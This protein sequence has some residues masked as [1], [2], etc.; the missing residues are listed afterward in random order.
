M[1]GPDRRSFLTYFS[2]IGLSATL[3]PGVLWAR[4]QETKQQAITM[5]MLKDAAAVAGVSFSDDQ[6]AAMLDGVNRNFEVSEKLRQIEFDYS[7]AP[8]LYYNPLVPGVKVDRVKRQIPTSK[9]PQVERPNDLEQVAFWPVRQ[10]AQLIKTKQVKSVEMTDMYLARLKKYNPKL[11]CA[12]TLTDDLAMKQARQADSEITAGKYKGPLHGIPWGV[13]D[14]FAVPGYPTTWGT[15]PYKDR[16]IDSEA[17][18]V[19]LIREAGGVLVAK[20]ATGEL[21]NEDQWFGGRTNNPWDL[22][23]G[24]SGSSAGP[25][26]ATAAGL[27][28][29]GVGTETG[30]S[31]LG[32]ASRCGVVGLRPTFGRVSRNGVMALAWNQDR[33]GP[34][35]RSAEDAALVFN[36]IC[37][38]DEF[39]QSVLDIPF[40]WD[41][42]MDLRKLRIGYLEEEL[43]ASD[44]GSGTNGQALDVLKSLGIAPEP[45]R[46]PDSLRKLHELTNNGFSLGSPYASEAGASFDDLVRFP[47]K[48]Q[49]VKNTSRRTFVPPSRVASAVDYLQMQRLRYVIMKQFAD[50]VVRFDVYIANGIPRPGGVSYTYL[51]SAVSPGQA[52]DPGKVHFDIANLCAYPAVAVPNGFDPGGHPTSIIFMGRLF[53]EA[54]A[55]AVAKAYQDA[56]KWHL[57][58]PPQFA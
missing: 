1:K 56:T 44:R 24:S 12:V 25:A 37:Q 27:V 19:R 48:W 5:D 41:A 50:A 6:Y 43:T 55:L 3:M 51:S 31:I 17:S 40:N 20:L 34:L 32:P 16:I 33:V 36:V 21:A 35:C 42:A 58:H 26:S 28:A 8:P 14:I 7:V 9:P 53:N 49:Q 52:N 11:N 54:A 47:D 13:K 18:V 57:K 4:L 39:D 10:L 30:G 2:S 23:E 22:N 46:L 38:R 45:F 29:F 15:L